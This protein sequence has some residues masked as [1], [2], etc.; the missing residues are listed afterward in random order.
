VKRYLRLFATYILIA[1][2]I[3]LLYAPWA[4][5]LRPTDYSI[6]RAGMSI[7][8]GVALAGVFGASTYF[9]LKDPDVKMLKPSKIMDD[10]EVI[11]VLEE[12]VDTPYVGGIAADAL[13]EVHSASRKKARLNKVIALQFSEGSL[14]WDRF[15]TLVDTAERTVLRNAALVANNVQSFD[16]EGYTKEKSRRKDQNEQLALYNE[17]LSRMQE[18]VEANERV[19]LEMGKLELELSKLEEDETLEDNGQTIEELQTLIDETRY[20][21]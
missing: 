7:I 3:V 15:V 8:A 16:R 4:L 13:E 17:S 18:I 6:L 10:D 21:R 12:Y 20:Y 11:P 1:V 9:A 5:A 14:S 19:L 2:A